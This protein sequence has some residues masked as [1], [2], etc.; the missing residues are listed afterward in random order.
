MTQGVL[1]VGTAGTSA[2]F[3]SDLG[4]AWV[5]PNSS[6][7]LYL[8]ARIWSMSCH[9]SNPDHL[10]AGTDFGVYRWS[11]TEQKW[12]HLPSPMDGRLVWAIAISP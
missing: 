9:P 1:Y 11:E 6:S 3:S 7:G 8:E 4:T 2:W 10:L 5:R 12:T